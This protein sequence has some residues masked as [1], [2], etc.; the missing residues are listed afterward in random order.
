MDAREAGC[1]QTTAAAK[2]GFSDRS[3]RRIESG[4]HQP[5]KGQPRDWRTR[6]DPLVEVWQGELEPMLKREPKLEAMTLFEYLQAHY[7]GQYQSVLR[8]VQRRVSEWKAQHGVAPEV[9]F[10]LRHTPGKMGYS[11][12]TELKK[13]TVTI[14]GKAFEHLLYHYRLAYS[15]WQYVQI[16]QGGE[17]YIALAEGLQNAL[18]AAGG[19]PQVHR[20]DSLTAA[21][22]N[23]GGKHRL[24]ERY[25]ALC[26]HYGM[27]SSR[28]NTGIAHENGS[29]ESSHGYF[30]R[31][32]VQQLYLRGSFEFARVEEYAAFIETVVAQLN[33]K[34]SEKFATELS[35]LQPLPKYRV[36]DYE[37][38]SVRVSCRST[39]DLKSVLYS[40]PERLI[41]RQ[42]TVHLYHNRWVGYL[43]QQVVVELPRLPVAS[44]HQGRR[45]RAIHYRHIIEGLQK[46][47][48][49]ALLHLDGRHLTD[50]DVPA[51]LAADAEHV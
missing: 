5:H 44:A 10:E 20:S 37:I 12:F 15:G 28:N 34:C 1:S 39:V 47:A 7:P 45:T 3:G 43:A 16:I 36:A 9:M 51:P 17:S 27:R 22:R 35:H 4:T 24:T 19:V 31:R 26:Q 40:V 38:L 42:L 8:T 23:S 41:G 18:A 2:A 14:G 30:K 50:S 13:V 29:I 6:V 25:E 33:A 48:C 11:D 49:L 46:A 32:L 21:Y